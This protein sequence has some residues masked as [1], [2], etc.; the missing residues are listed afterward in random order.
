MKTTE[1]AVRVVL[2]DDSALVREHVAALLA[3]LEG[4][5]VVAQA[6]D[7]ATAKS[8]IQQLR[9]D[10]LVLDIG[11]PGESGI[12]LLKVVRPEIASLVI[13][14]FSMYSDPYCRRVCAEAGADYF[15]DKALEIGG[16]VETLRTLV[17]ACKS[18]RE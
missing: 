17:A 10:V 2:V 3:T 8:L 11:L 5:E 16:L 1:K 12:S 14:M 4:V 9:P 6:S 13:I 15:F 7:A 18:E